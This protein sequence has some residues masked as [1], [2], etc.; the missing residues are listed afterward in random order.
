MPAKKRERNEPEIYSETIDIPFVVSTKLKVFFFCFMFVILVISFF[1]PIYLGNLA[2]GTHGTTRAWLWLV[3]AIIVIVVFLNYMMLRKDK[4]DK[5]RISATPKSIA[6]SYNGQDKAVI[7]WKEIDDCYADEHFRV[8]IK[9]YRRH[10]IVG[11]IWWIDITYWYV[12][13]FIPKTEFWGTALVNGKSRLAYV[14]LLTESRI[15]LRL[16][17]AYPCNIFR[18]SKRLRW[19]LPLRR[20]KFDE[21]VFESRKPDKMIE[22]IKQNI[23]KQEKQE[24]IA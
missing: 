9:K 8:G 17:T 23:G 5:Y 11:N 12:P 3:P 19:W 2:G 24:T 14:P 15:V 21:F 6:V 13:H 20:R 16:K 4:V 10:P 22:I 18:V 1:A 7:F